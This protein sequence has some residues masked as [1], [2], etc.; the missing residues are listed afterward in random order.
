MW[1]THSSQRLCKGL[2]KS[3][4]PE[5]GSNNLNDQLRSLRSVGSLSRKTSSQ[6]GGALKLAAGSRNASQVM[7]QRHIGTSSRLPE[8]EMR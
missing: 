4:V 2:E 6:S 3:S 7:S 8:H 1:Q 5:G